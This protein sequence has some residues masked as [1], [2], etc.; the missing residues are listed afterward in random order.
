MRKWEAVERALM[1][2]I[3]D[4][5]DE[6]IASQRFIYT[7][8]LP[9]FPE[10]N[11]VYIMDGPDGMH[12]YVPTGERMHDW[13]DIGLMENRGEIEEPPKM[14]PTNCTNCGAPLKNGKCAYCGTEY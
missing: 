1:G 3:E 2:Y 6:M 11:V 14:R 9:A 12:G 4:V 7:S 5:L 13:L 8:K 10:R